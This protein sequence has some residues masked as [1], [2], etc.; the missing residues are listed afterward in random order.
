MVSIDDGPAQPRKVR[1]ILFANCGKLPAGI[2]FIPT[3]EIDDGELDIVVLSPR[4]V[5]GWLWI[6]A[7]TL[8]RHNAPIP[9]IEYHRGRKV[10][11]TTQE[12]MGSQLDGD[13]TG[14]VTSLTVEVKPRSLAVRTESVAAA[15]GRAV[16]L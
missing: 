7:K 5:A 4:S 1:S 2:D 3:A 15:H 14:P 13:P 9:V 11:I 12:P 8:V 10:R 6:A 16:P